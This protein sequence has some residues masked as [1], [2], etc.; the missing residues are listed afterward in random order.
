[1]RIWVKPFVAWIWF[2]CLFMGLGGM[3]AVTDR[4]YRTRATSPSSDTAGSGATA[5]R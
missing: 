4:R 2:G 1:V 5:V 3:W